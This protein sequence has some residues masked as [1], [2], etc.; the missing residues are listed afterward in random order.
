MKKIPTTLFFVLIFCLFANAQSPADVISTMRIGPFKI[1]MPKT[2]VEKIIGQKLIRNEGGYV[3]SAVFNYGNT[4]YIVVFNQEYVEEGSKL[5]KL[6]K[7]YSIS[8]SNTKLKTKSVIGIGSTKAQILQAYDKYDLTI[9]N[10]YSYKEKENPKDK[11]QFI[12]LSDG[13][14]GTQITFTTEN[15]VVTKIEISVFEGC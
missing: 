5:P 15:R 9:S 14:A 13:E 11:V 12:T 6:W 7:I 1:N 3:D 4:N 2:E 10:D 8:S